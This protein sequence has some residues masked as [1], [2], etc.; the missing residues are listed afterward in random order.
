VPR[1]AIIAVTMERISGKVIAKFVVAVS[2]SCV[3]A[4]LTGSSGL[5]LKFEKQDL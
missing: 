4:R 1:T 3:I 2:R 5:G